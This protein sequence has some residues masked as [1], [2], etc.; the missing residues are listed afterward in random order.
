MAIHL[1]ELDSNFLSLNFYN[2]DPI[3]LKLYIAQLGLLL[4]LGT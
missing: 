1:F 4:L 2:I 3:K